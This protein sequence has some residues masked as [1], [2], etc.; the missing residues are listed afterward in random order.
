MEIIFEE[1]GTALLGI[2]AG[3]AMIFVL[4]KLVYG[5]EVVGGFLLQFMLGICG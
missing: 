5:G 1:Y 3:G 4:W 2:V